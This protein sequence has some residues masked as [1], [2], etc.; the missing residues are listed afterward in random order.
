M[1]RNVIFDIGNVFVRWSPAV[2]VARS[3][4]DAI[5]TDENTARVNQLF[6]SPIWIDLNLGRLTQRE[7]KRAYQSAYGYSPA[8][9]ASLSHHAHAHQDPI[10]G[11][12]AL[13][14]KLVTNG[15][16]VFALT[17]NVC[18][19]INELRKRCS[20][21]D[22]FEGVAVSAE[23]GHKKPGPEIFRHLFHEHDI[24]PAAAVFLDDRPPNVVG[25][26]ALGMQA[27][28]FDNAP[29]ASE[30]LQRLGVTI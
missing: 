8:Q 24:D 16:R 13:A 3:F 17:D 1:I 28:L 6:K 23:I 20:F 4:G 22:L 26:E 18:E 7:A 10:E 5:G 19:I 21:W 9:M 11:T 2:V 25:G 27:I 12:E 29:Q 14:R 15:C 30:E